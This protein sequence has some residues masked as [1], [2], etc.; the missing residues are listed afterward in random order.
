MLMQ[1]MVMIILTTS[2]TGY[3]FKL[4]GN[5]VS[6]ESRKQDSLSLS[7]TEAEYKGLND[8]TRECIHLYDLLNGLVEGIK[9]GI[10]LS[11]FVSELTDEKKVPVIFNDNQ[12]AQMLSKNRR[13]SKRIKHAQLK[14]H[15]VREAIEKNKVKLDYIQSEELMADL[16]TKGLSGSKTE[17]FCHK[18]NLIA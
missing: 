3:V 15:F 16:L 8:A 14:Y 5:V 18:L 6:W 7:S 11:N 4:G 1:P 9:E 10:Y 12:S 2:Y 17:Y 13:F